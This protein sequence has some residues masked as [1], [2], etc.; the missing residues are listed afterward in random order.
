MLY[1]FID[2][3]SMNPTTSSV[4]IGP[5][6]A[7][8]E[9]RWRQFSPLPLDLPLHRTLI[10]VPQALTFPSGRAISPRRNS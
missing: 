8:P 7:E 3:P 10:P 6:H 2:L 1:L 5:S 9:G 4:G